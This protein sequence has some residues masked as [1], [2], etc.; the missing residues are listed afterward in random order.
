MLHNIKE[1]VRVM[2]EN[3]LGEMLH[4]EI[5]PH[6]CFILWLSEVCTIKFP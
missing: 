4:N 3:L 6:S 1:E 5:K 2:Q